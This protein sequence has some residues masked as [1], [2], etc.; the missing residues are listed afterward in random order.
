MVTGDQMVPAEL[1]GAA[2]EDGTAIG[3]GQERSEL[4]SMPGSA[5]SSRY[6]SGHAKG[7]RP[8]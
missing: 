3:E 2:I 6:V 7:R 5:A 8:G 4:P 1:L